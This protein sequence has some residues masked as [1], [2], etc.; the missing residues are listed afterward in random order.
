MVPTPDGRSL[1]SVRFSLIRNI[2]TEY[3]NFLG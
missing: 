2:N 1:E 3:G